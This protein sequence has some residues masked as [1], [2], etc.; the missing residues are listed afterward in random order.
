MK[1][2]VIELR[3]KM[4][5]IIKALDRNESITIL[6]HGKVKG[7]LVP[8]NE[9][10][11]CKVAEHPFFGMHRE[12]AESVHEVMATLRGGRFHDL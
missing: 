10:V 2:S 3:S 11:A 8:V 6:Y 9:T 5:Q 4:S 7:T 12:E 1:A